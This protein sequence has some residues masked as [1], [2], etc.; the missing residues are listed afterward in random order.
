[1]SAEYEGESI[2]SERVI[3]FPGLNV[4][5]LASC[6]ATASAKSVFSLA[7]DEG[8]RRI[9]KTCSKKTGTFCLR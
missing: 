3:R 6:A 9:R 2:S 7:P 5:Q 1:M 8:V 4:P